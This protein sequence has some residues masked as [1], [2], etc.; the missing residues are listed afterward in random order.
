MSVALLRKMFLNDNMGKLQHFG[1]EVPTPE[2]RLLVPSAIRS[3]AMTKASDS[4]DITSKLNQKLLY[5]G[6]PL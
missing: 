5:L 3:F 4:D 1:I 2:K 6:T